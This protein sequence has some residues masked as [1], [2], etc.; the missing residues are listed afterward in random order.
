MFG[1]FS[2]AKC[3][4]ESGTDSPSRSH[5]L[6]DGEEEK[7]APDSDQEEATAT[8]VRLAELASPAEATRKSNLNP[9][10]GAEVAQRNRDRKKIN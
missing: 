9:K 5:G 1:G 4:A 3:D 8:A 10:A 7:K 6:D 2:L